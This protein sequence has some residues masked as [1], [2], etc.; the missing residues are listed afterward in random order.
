MTTKAPSNGD[1]KVDCQV[2]PDV[3]QDQA[4]NVSPDTEDKPEDCNNIGTIGLL[5]VNGMQ[6]YRY[7]HYGGA[8]A[9]C[10]INL[11]VCHNLNN[12]HDYGLDESNDDGHDFSD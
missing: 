9:N 4:C 8:D 12:D 1:N 3:S 10:D 5:I 11:E 2:S 6:N 7:L